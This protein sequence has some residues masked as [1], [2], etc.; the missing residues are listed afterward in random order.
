[1][2]LTPQY[3]PL[4][5][6]SNIN[7]SNVNFE[8]IENLYELPCEFLVENQEKLTNFL[9][10]MEIVDE[11]VA[12]SVINFDSNSNLKINYDHIL[13]QFH[14]D[15]EKLVEDKVFCE[16]IEVLKN[17]LNSVK[18]YEISND[19]E[20][21]NQ[22]LEVN[23]FENI[24]GNNEIPELFDLIENF[25]KIENINGNDVFYEVQE[26]YKISKV[27]VKYIIIVFLQGRIYN[28]LITVPRCYHKIT[29]F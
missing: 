17:D 22:N 4:I 8:L 21:T 5:I 12:R 3:Q 6:Q 20:D 11:C 7:N 10:P 27:I 18:N 15:D 9:I 16:I 25:E 2:D 28:F 14:V 29:K 23:E 24:Q 26:T 1:M 19:E 13:C